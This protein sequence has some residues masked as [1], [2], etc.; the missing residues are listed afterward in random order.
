MNL[1][2]S[3][4]KVVQGVFMYN[5]SKVAKAVRIAMMFGAG[6]AATISV[7]AFSAEDAESVKSVERI[8]VTGSRIKR[9]DMETSSP[10]QITSAEDI[11]VS[12][13]TRVEDMLNTLPQIE[14]SSTAFEANGASG[15]AGVD[16]R[17]LGSHRTLVL[18]NGRRM[19]P[20]G[21]SNGAADLNAIPSALVK[22]VEVMT[23]GGS[24][25]YGADA[26]AGV[27]NFVMDDDFEGLKIDLG[28]SGF[29]HNND[30]KY[31]QDL[32]DQKGFEYEEGNTDIDGT[33]FSIDI[34]AGGAFANG[35]GHAV[36][37]ATYKKTNELRQSAR[38]YSSCAL[39][40]AGTS[41]GGSANA[42]IPN[43]DMYPRLG[44]GTVVPAGAQLPDGTIATVDTVLDEAATYYSAN[45]FL[46]LDS[47]SNFID[48][49]SSNRYNYAPINHFMRPDDKYTIGAF[50][51]YEI[52]DTF[53]PYMEVS[54]MQDKTKAQIAESG[55]FFNEEYLISSDSNLLTSAQ[56][57]QISN[58]FGWSMEQNVLDEN[59]N[60]TFDDDGEAITT[61]SMYDINVEN[62]TLINPFTTD[63]F[64]SY[65]G[66]RNV[67]GGPRVDAIQHD[68]FRVVLGS[69]GELI[70]TWTYDASFQYSN[71]TT[72][73][74]Y[75]NDF[76]G[77]R[78]TTALS[79]SG[80][81]CVGD[82][83]PYEV[84]KYNGV[85]PEQAK[86]LTGTAIL[87][88]SS[89]RLILSGFATG[90][91][92]FTMPTAS[93]P[94]M[95][96]IGV[97]YRDEQFERISDDL[98]ETGAL[99]GQGGPTKSLQGGY[100]VR[101]LYGEAS[102]PLI[103]DADFAE[104]LI[105]ELGYRYSDY[106]LSGSEPTYKVAFD[107][108]PIDDWKVR[109]SYNRAVR[110]PNIGELFASQSIGLWSG[111]DP[112][113][114]ATPTL[115]ASECANTGV[116]SAQYGSVSASPAGQYNGFFGGNP[117]LAPEIADTYTVGVVGQL[118]DNMSFSL[119]YWTI[120]IEDVI[121]NIEP[122]LTVEQC[123]KTGNAAFCDNIKRSPS[124]NLWLGQAGFVGATDLNLASQKWEGVDLSGSYST[125]IAG[126]SLK[127]T[128]L[129]TYMMTKETQSLP[130]DQE[131]IYDC[132][133]GI[134]GLCFPQPK[135]RHVMNVNFD[136]DDWGVNL[137]WRFLGKVDYEG[138][139][140]KLIADG[141]SSQT[142][143]DLAGHYVVSDNIVA[144]LG[145]N[146]ILDKEKPITGNTVD[147]GAYYDGLGRFIH[148]SMTFQF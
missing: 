116:S 115:S 13:F 59:G 120:E 28:G 94:V 73:N 138:T 20:G 74:T 128:I 5:N 60:Q 99:L 84:F 142:Y 24:S 33:S 82:C 26:V 42:I 102:V 7:P 54:F 117:D 68:T 63:E 118:S 140:D 1:N 9:V 75:Q 137:K 27:V 134:S 76:F 107:W 17:G 79:A 14:A 47:D 127:A 51:N 50:V 133:D 10:I 95:V 144:R 114:G 70:N 143:I 98:Y 89:E 146:N 123:A 121:D 3:I 30:N 135:W 85:T 125:D 130:G 12:G 112:C 105:L 25:T 91:L 110:A 111:E 40:A 57:D 48:A 2:T 36:A 129:G 86:P 62:P 65:I 88:T 46:S 132:M 122:E 11:K 21:S 77:P 19:A 80:E 131:S 55:T 108:T 49:P 67:E 56:Q 39:S 147:T 6:A 103:E 81:S 52:N 29:Q 64:A 119:D 139:T 92:D 38:D 53:Q 136:K 66:K 37:Y 45:Q 93:S 101:E 72:T 90:E 58:A 97:E 113:A 61:A 145:I 44:A 87:T 35:K 78:I 83:I 31:I 34:T 109:A 4:T 15:T 69:E 32:M 22:R 18:I 106:S 23:G 8:E 148:A 126:G 43:F 16:M 71:T 100:S 124:G 141:I 41:C 104:S 96:V